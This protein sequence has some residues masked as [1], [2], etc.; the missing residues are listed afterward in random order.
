MEAEMLYRGVKMACI[1]LTGALLLQQIDKERRSPNRSK[2]V[3]VRVG[4]VAAAFVASWL[5]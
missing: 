5:M 3:L 2:M 4:A 1:L